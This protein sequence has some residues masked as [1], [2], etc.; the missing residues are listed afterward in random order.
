MLKGKNIIL[1]VSAGIAA[2]KSALLTRLLV[3]NGAEVKVVMT[4]KAKE[5]ITPLT[6]ATLSKNPIMVDFYNP[7]NGDWNSHVDLG[8]W[9]DAMVVAPATANTM[10]KMANAIADNLLV[11]TYLSARC[12]VFVAPTMDLDMYLHPANQRNMKQLEEDGVHIIEAGSGELASGLSGKGRM[13]EPE[14]IVDD[15]ITFFQKQTSAKNDQL[16]GRTFLVNAGP[17]Y[18]KI[19]PVRYIGNFSSGKMG[20]SIAEELAQRGAEVVLVSGPVNQKVKSERIKLIHV[21]SAQEMYQACAEYF[22]NCDGAVLSAAVADYTPVICADQKV[23]SDDD[24]MVVSLKSTVD[25]ASKLGQMKKEGQV[26]VGFALETEN[27]VKNALK[28]LEKKN[29]DFIVLNSLENTG[30]GFGHDT[31]QITIIDR[32]NNKEEFSLKSKKEV[33]IDIVDKIISL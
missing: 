31:N 12:P 2:Y 5:F 22:P 4:E 20:Y 10:G 3:K 26:L 21:T 11:T 8:L 1:G 15:L 16:K 33:A 7:E 17:T 24:Q 27:A 25:I 14:T 18:E 28:K 6:M 9:A 23:K 19:D 30:A 13:A 32:N 29:L